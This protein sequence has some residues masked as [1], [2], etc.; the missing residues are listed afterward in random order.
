MKSRKAA[1]RK[2]KE[3]KRSERISLA[4]AVAPLVCIVLEFVIKLF[5]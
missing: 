1:R 3:L 4:I 2:E 5:L